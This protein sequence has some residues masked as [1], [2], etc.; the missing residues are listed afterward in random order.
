MQSAASDLALMCAAAREAGALARSRMGG[1]I[2]HWRK[3]DSSVVTAIDLE[4]DRLLEQRLRAARPD[5][6]WLS[7]EKADTAARLTKRDVF[8]V[9]PIDGTSALIDGAPEFSISIGLA[10]DGR[11]AAGVIYNPITD[12]LFAGGENAAPTLN[13]APISVTQ[14]DILEDA[15]LVGK[16]GFFQAPPWPTPWPPMRFTYVRSLALRL[17]TVAAGRA[18]GAVLL[19]FKNEWDVIAGCA[20]VAAAGGAFTDPWGEAI[21]FNA[22]DPRAPGLVAAGPALHRQLIQRS[23][24][25]SHPSTWRKRQGPVVRQE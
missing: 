9:D 20:I 10:R 16:K 15:E 5:Y 12:E 24:V 19:G 17:A 1:V 11:A 23:K 8:I 13:G 2:E 18:D 3:D 21:S 25:A 7:E 4:I 6:G 14:R 22:A